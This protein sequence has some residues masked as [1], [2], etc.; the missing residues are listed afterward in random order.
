MFALPCDIRQAIEKLLDDLK[1]AGVFLVPVGEL[2]DWLAT[3][4]I[5]ESKTNK[6]AWANAAALAVL[7][8]KGDRTGDIWDFARGVGSYLSRQ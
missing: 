5:T 4:N 2:E 7:S 6:S 1:I 3:E 8:S